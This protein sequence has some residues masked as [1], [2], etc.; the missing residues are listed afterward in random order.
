MLKS[1]LIARIGEKLPNT[2][3]ENIHLGINFILETFRTSLSANRTI[4]IRGFGTFRLR[5]HP[6][7]ELYNL[8]TKKKELIQARQV[9]HFKPGKTLQI[10]KITT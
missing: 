2:P 6:A 3:L 1:H 8:K 10:S 7:K 5:E 4:S 9:V